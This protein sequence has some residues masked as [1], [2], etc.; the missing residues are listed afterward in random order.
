MPVQFEFFQKGE[1]IKLRQFH[2]V[3]CSSLSLGGNSYKR[4]WH[5]HPQKSL[6]KTKQKETVF[7][8]FFFSQLLL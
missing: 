8:F 7:S 3:F 1:L 2:K 6:L 4:D 5:H